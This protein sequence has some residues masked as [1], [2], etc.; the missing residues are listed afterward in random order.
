MSLYGERVN[1]D[2]R[3]SF[4]LIGTLAQARESLLKRTMR[5]RQ[6]S[7][8]QADAGQEANGDIK[9]KGRELRSGT[10]RGL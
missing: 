4:S 6:F 1:L 8:I 2:C 7:P 9:L 3:E 5:R 10:Y